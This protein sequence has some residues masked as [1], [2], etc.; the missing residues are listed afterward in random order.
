MH[1]DRR[2]RLFDEA[3]V[4]EL[5][6]NSHRDQLSFNYTAWKT[7]FLPGYLSN[8]FRV[9]GNRYFRMEKHG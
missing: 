2:C 7:G 9:N 4:V 3:W 6:L 1:N 5:L 8:Q